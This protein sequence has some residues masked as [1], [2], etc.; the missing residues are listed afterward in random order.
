MLVAYVF[1]LPVF[2]STRSFRSVSSVLIP[3]STSCLP[4][5]LL[6]SLRPCLFH[7]YFVA[8][9]SLTPLLSCHPTIG[10]PLLTASL[11]GYCF[12]PPVFR[13]SSAHG[14]FTAMSF[15]HDFLSPSFTPHSGS[16]SLPSPLS[17]RMFSFV[18]FYYCS[19]PSRVSPL[20]RSF[21]LFV[22]HC[23]RLWALNSTHIV[24]FPAFSCAA[25][26]PLV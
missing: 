20:L 19:A 9:F 18:H 2:L 26:P 4:R 8:L 1:Q 25:A 23:R 13:S 21:L 11:S 15:L 7:C 17:R 6:L 5:V 16:S 22:R 24:T 10:I 12:F 14:P 3:S